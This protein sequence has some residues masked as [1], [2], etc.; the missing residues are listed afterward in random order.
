[1]HFWSTVPSSHLNVAFETASG[2]W[3]TMMAIETMAFSRAVELKLVLI[4]GNYFKWNMPLIKSSNAFL[5][6]LA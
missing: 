4:L 5:C 1:M 2:H 6:S 3:A